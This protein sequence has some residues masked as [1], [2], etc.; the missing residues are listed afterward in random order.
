MELFK[1]WLKTNVLFLAH[2]RKFS[3]ARSQSPDSMIRIQVS[4]MLMR[5]LWLKWDMYVSVQPGNLLAR[6]WRS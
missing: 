2:Y 5:M 6:N 3:G 1:L 4:I